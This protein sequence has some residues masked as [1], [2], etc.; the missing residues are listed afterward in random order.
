MSLFLNQNQVLPLKRDLAARFVPKMIALMVYLGTLCSVFT[1]FMLE[2]S[3]TWTNQL[4]TQLS[5]EVPTSSDQSVASLEP[6]VLELLN[7]T[8]GIETVTPVPPQDM[9]NLLHTLLG[10][11]I[12]LDLLSLPSVI[13][14]SLQKNASFES[15]VL[16][17]H[18]KNI[19]P[20]IQITDH[21][22]WQA[23]V[24]GVIG[25]S[26][27][28]AI[29]LTLLILIAA[30]ITTT[31]ATQTSLLIHREVID[32]LRLLGAT[33][34]YIAQQFQFNT[35]KQGLIASGLGSGLSFITFAGLVFLLEQA[36]LPLSVP[37]SFYPQSLAIFFLAPPL[38]AAAMMLS[39]RFA[40]MKALEK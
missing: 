40:V 22:P 31:F 13:D 32:L 7:R 26:L 20:L 4:T 38:T 11:D 27:S 1:L 39:A 15:A 37:A 3:Q 35:L 6:R 34:N 28:I 5:I 16:E 18:L 9:A 23:Q 12:N 14:V 19:S 29:V 10:K 36:G 33:H 25:T 17:T 8:P 2:S 24:S 30:L 21:R